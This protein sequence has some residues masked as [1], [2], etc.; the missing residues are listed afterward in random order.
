MNDKHFNFSFVKKYFSIVSL[1]LILCFI[2]PR[3]P[4]F[5]KS[6]F[7]LLVKAAKVKFGVLFISITRHYGQKFLF[8]NTSKE[9]MRLSGAKVVFLSLKKYINKWESVGFENRQLQQQ[10]HRGCTT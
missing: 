3:S 9:S 4:Q 2:Y 6:N 8:Y 7:F 1:C 5:P 10:Q